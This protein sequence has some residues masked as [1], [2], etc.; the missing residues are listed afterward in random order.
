[1]HFEKNFVDY[2][3]IYNFFCIGDS[4]AIHAM[5][6]NRHLVAILRYLDTTEKP[7][8]ALESAMREPIF[9]EFADE[10]LRIVEPDQENCTYLDKGFIIE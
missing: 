7:E 8:A 4:P 10:C 6:K 1:M 2:L 5:I 3:L 9:V